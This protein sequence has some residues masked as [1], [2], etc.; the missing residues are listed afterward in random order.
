MGFTSA[1]GPTR[2]LFT[3]ATAKQHGYP[4]SLK[5][6]HAALSG[7]K[8]HPQGTAWALVYNDNVCRGGLTLSSQQWIDRAS[9]AVRFYKGICLKDGFYKREGSDATAVYSSDG[10]TAWIPAFSQA[11][12]CCAESGLKA[13]PQGTAWALVHNDNVCRGGLTLSSQ[14]WIDRA[15]MNSDAY[16]GICLKDGFYVLKTDMLHAIQNRF[17]GAPAVNFNV[18]TIRG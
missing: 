2:P 15:S 12:P 16:K 14:Q 13:H 6:L 7:L 1:R 3:R 8:A 5:R 17:Q 9:R 10:K 4:R 18:G 11:P